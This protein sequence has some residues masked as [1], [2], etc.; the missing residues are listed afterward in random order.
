MGAP[1]APAAARRLAPAP[2]QAPPR[3]VAPI[4]QA[5]PWTAPRPS[6]PWRTFAS[7]ASAAAAAG[8]KAYRPTTPGFRG[9]VVTS[10]TGLWK[11][12]PHKRL[13]VGLRKSGGRGAD[14]R[15]NVRHRGGG[16]RKVY[17]VVDF[18]RRNDASGDG[19]GGDKPFTATV[20][21]IEYDPNRSARIALL[22][23]TDP[24]SADP[25]VTGSDGRSYILAPA[26]LAAGDSVAAGPG[27]P[28]APGSC[29]PL[30]AIPAGTPVHNVELLPGGGGQ[31]ARAAGVA[32]VVV[33]RGE[34]GKRGCSGGR[35]ARRC[36]FLPPHPPPP[37][38][39]RRPR[40]VRH[41]APPL[42]RPT[43]RAGLLP[44]DRRR[45]LQRGPQKSRPRQSGRVPVG[46]QAPKSAGRGHEQCRP[47]DGRRPRQEQGA[48]Q[49]VADRRPGQGQEDAAADLAHGRLCA[50]GAASGAQVRREG[51]KGCVV[52]APVFSRAL[53]PS[54]S[55][56]SFAHSPSLQGR[57]H[58]TRVTQTGCRAAAAARATRRARRRP[59]HPLLHHSLHRPTPPPTPTHASTHPSRRR[60]ASSRPRW[61]GGW[62]RAARP[63]SSGEGG[64]GRQRGGSPC[65]GRRRLWRRE[66]PPWRLPPQPR[67]RRRRRPRGAGGGREEG[68]PSP[69]RGRPRA[70]GRV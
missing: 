24:L 44:R 5:T 30:S 6:F 2:P 15:I 42:R 11:G 22:S 8:L 40:R 26:G 48:D 35:R 36:F 45:A 56:L 52:A 12:S 63:R 3:A 9:R 31:M 20:E 19:G 37:L 65:A 39:L 51:G 58:G 21:R 29:L 70:V 54:L 17:R 66:Q 28:V 41:R 27:A 38:P 55:L 60:A 68:R 47:P 33:S 18:W 32:A 16:H 4:A 67:Q 25:R 10:R 50:R 23:A 7:Q 49:S 61:G 62:A 53:F 57:R 13:T 1:P 46:G 59:R 69:A 64:G 43:P 14:G 34:G